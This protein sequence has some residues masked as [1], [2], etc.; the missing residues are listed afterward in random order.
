MKGALWLG[1]AL[2]CSLALAA[3][4]LDRQILSADKVETK[5][6]SIQGVLA[7]DESSEP[8]TTFT[9]NAAKIAVRWKGSGLHAGDK[10]RAVWL[11]EDVGIAAP[12]NSRIT[13]GSVTAYKPDDMGH[14]PC[15]GRREVGR[16]VNIVWSFILTPGWRRSFDSKSSRTWS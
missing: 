6:G 3:D 10:V 15:H 11:A 2:L 5:P 16:R 8:T 4:P 9:T 1:M 12:K 14:W 7:K 13:A